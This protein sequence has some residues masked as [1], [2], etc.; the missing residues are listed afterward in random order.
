MNAADKAA[1][2]ELRLLTIQYESGLELAVVTGW[3]GRF[4]TAT[5]TPVEAF[6]VP[7]RDEPLR[8][9][10]MTRIPWNRVVSMVDHGMPK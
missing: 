1:A 9:Q 4:D 10:T 5:G 2:A 8:L 6:V 3:G 7:D